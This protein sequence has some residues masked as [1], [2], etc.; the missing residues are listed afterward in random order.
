MLYSRART[1]RRT[2][3]FLRRLNRQ[4][5]LA[6]WCDQRRAADATPQTVMPD[7]VYK[8]FLT[9][10]RIVVRSDRARMHPRS[11]GYPFTD[12]RPGR[13]RAS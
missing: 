1:D 10:M 5:S 11:T 7:E 3:F 4:H 8:K 2:I 13:A 12:T 9:E 6:A